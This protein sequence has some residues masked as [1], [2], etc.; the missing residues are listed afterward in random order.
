MSKNFIIEFNKLNSIIFVDVL[1][2]NQ[3]IHLNESHLILK[4]TT[5]LWRISESNR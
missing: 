3:M 2:L 4:R 1:D 5:F